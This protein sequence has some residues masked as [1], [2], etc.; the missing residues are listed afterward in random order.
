MKRETKEKMYVIAAIAVL[1][2]MGLVIT[3]APAAY[4]R[5]FGSRV[6]DSALL[7]IAGGFGGFYLGFAAWLLLSIRR[8]ATRDAAVKA[9]VA[10]MGGLVFARLA[11]MATIGLPP[12]AMFS[13]LALESAMAAWGVFLAARKAGKASDGKAD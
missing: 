9:I 7:G 4:L 13:A 5:L 11:G 6:E 10:V 12:P 2:P 3:F 1:A 8:G